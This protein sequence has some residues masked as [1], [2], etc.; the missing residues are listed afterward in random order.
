MLHVWQNKLVEDHDSGNDVAQSLTLEANALS[1]CAW[2]A[3][4]WHEGTNITPSCING[5][6]E[7]GLSEVIHDIIPTDG[8]D[9]FLGDCPQLSRDTPGI[10][11]PVGSV[12]AST[13][14]TKCRLFRSLRR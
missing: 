10:V 4:R 11:G 1:F 3:W 2:L 6:F 5:T 14:K 8:R 12:H 9:C 13:L 7:D